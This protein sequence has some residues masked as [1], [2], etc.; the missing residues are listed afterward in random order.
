MQLFFEEDGNYKFG[1]IL[2]HE[3]N[4]YQVELAS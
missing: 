2:K 3:G 1:V 4:A